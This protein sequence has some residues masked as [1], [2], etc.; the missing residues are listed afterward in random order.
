[1]AYRLLG[2]GGLLDAD[3]LARY[4]GS[5]D[6]GD[7]ALLEVDL[8]LPVSAGI[9]SELQT[10]LRQAG[11]ED[12]RVTTASPLVRV[13]FKK[14]FPWL[15]VIAAVIL[16]LII[17]AVLIVGWRLYKDVTPDIPGGATTLFWVGMVVLG[18]GILIYLGR[19]RKL[20]A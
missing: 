20:R 2:Q 17:L 19:R 1:M 7:K 8:R 4:E 3:D 15:A 9:A 11:V 10:R 13:Y 14:G 12:A 5:L 16:G 6:E 18:V